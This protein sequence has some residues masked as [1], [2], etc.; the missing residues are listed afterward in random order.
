MKTRSFKMERSDWL[1]QLAIGLV[2]IALFAIQ[3]PEGGALLLVPALLLVY[4][5]RST[6]HIEPELKRIGAVFILYVLF[7]TVV[8]TDPSRSAKGGYDIVR[9]LLVFFPAVWLGGQLTKV[10]GK[11]IGL[12]IGLLFILAN[13]AFPGIN[14]V[15]EFYGFYDN[16]NNVAVTLAGYLFLLVALYPKLHDGSRKW[17]LLAFIT[18]L[19]AALF[20]LALANSRG[21]WLGVAVAFYLIALLQKNIANRIKLA[22]FFA[23]G[24]GLLALVVLVDLKGFGYGTVGAR[25]EIWKGLWALTVTDHLWLGYG[26]N[27][28]KD[29]LTASALPTLTAHNIFLELFV[30]TGLIGV[31]AF[32]YIAY[33][34]S[35]FLLKQNY[36]GGPVLYAGIGGLM[37]FLV[38]GQFDLK[39]ASYK[40]IAMVSCFLGLIYS[41]RLQTTTGEQSSK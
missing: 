41:Q 25:I 31:A 2:L 14:G 12:S 23:V 37:A 9:G 36:A 24:A 11:S 30:S 4:M 16:P 27:S 28:V 10:H 5:Q 26:I 35:V 1:A 18:A 38:M 32:T 15:Q 8:S 29:I 13:F 3:L 22:L 19:C 40:F 7:F 21:S 33:R 6:F 34:L 17:H 20:L 39:F